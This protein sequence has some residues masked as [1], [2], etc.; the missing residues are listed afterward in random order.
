MNQISQLA[1]IRGSNNYK[2]FDRFA[3]A[4]YVDRNA[5]MSVNCGI[6]SFE[7]TNTAR[8]ERVRI[9]TGTAMTVRASF[10]QSTIFDLSDGVTKC[11]EHIRRD[12]GEVDNST[13]YG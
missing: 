11:K 13:K 1:Q 6:G 2:T 4:M 10:D 5:K 7:L 12:P 3:H 9:N 8:S